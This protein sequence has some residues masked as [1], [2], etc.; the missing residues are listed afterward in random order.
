[1][2]KNIMNMQDDEIDKC[3]SYFVAEV[4]NKSGLVYKCEIHIEQ[5]NISFK[6]KFEILKTYVD[7]R[8]NLDLNTIFLIP[9]KYKTAF[10]LFSTRV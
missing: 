5:G 1:M 9:Q 4:R 6:F 3:L 2:Y 7:N 10:G 8:W